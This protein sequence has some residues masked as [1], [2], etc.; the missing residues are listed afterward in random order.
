M[1]VETNCDSSNH[2]EQDQYPNDGGIGR[3]WVGGVLMDFGNLGISRLV[4][5]LG[6][7]ERRIVAKGRTRSRI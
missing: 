6:R 7:E 3:E 2:C 4:V 1:I 5:E